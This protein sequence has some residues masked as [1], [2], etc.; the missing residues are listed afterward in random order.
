MKDSFGRA[1]TYARI[2]LTDLCNLRCVYCMGECGVEKKQH[3]DMLSLENFYEIIKALSALGVNKV[4]FTGGEPL[5]KKNVVSL[6]EKTAQLDGI[7]KISMTTNGVRLAS[8]AAE[9]KEAGL[10]GVNVS[11]DS[12]DEK[13]Y[14]IIT[15][16]GE[17]SNAMMGLETALKVGLK[18]KVNAVL[19]RGINDSEIENFANFG[20]MLGIEVRFIEL[21]PFSNQ[22]DFASSHFISANELEKTLHLT[23]LGTKD[24]SNAFYY[25][26]EKGNEIAIIS[27]VSEKFCS[28]CNR[29]RITADGKLLNCLHENREFDLKPYLGNFEAL[30]SYIE[31]CVR[32]KPPCH[33]IG[34]VKEQHRNMTKIGG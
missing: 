14:K 22:S 19:M 16:G 7:E 17:L 28:K 20:Q 5:L 2:S 3:E 34:Q 32:E 25:K 29:V 27:P 15:R 33:K 12:L 31:Q 4:R 8:L 24:S 23:R 6:V 11:I 18:V 26:T 13:K 9:L 10:Q 21:M 30:K 1:I